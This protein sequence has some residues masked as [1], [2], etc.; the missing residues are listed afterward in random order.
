MKILHTEASPGWGGQE[1]R[2]LK[3][4]EGMRERGHEVILVIQEGGG[5]VE[6]AR[7]SGFTVYELPMVRS[8]LSLC[9]AQLIRI[10]RKHGIEVI[11]THSSF[12]SWL[13]G[14][15]GRLLGKRVFRTR[16]LSTPIR[17]GLNSVILYNWLADGVITT[18][19]AVVPTIVSQAKLSFSRCQSIPTGVDF[20]SLLAHKVNP[21]QFREKWGIKSTDFLVGTLCILRSWKGVSDFLQAAA[22]LKEIPHLKWMIVG[23]GVSEENFLKEC[24][25]RGLE[26][27]VIFTGYLNP[28][29]EALAS[30]DVFLL[31][32]WANEGVSQAS[33]QAA[34]L[35][36]P[37]I[38]T[39]IG[40]LPEVCIHEKTG[41]VVQPH[42]PKEVANAVLKMMES[43]EKKRQDM[44]EAAYKLVQQ[45][46]SFEKMLDKMEAFYMQRL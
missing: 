16:H 38:T 5:L 11:N 46:F 6:P 17:K 1:I 43:S 23:N 28:P 13:A 39:S 22:L 8:H 24:K 9:F 30:M 44:G 18:C 36:K 35:K 2:I 34:G 20:S 27:R 14:I 25:Q 37:L 7:N 29:F 21:L 15:V 40:G 4:A 31:L 41:F 32:S 26:N 33:L 3:E 45:E 10:V 42:A 19:Q 12:D